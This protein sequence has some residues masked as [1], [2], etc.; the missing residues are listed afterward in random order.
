M[1][2]EDPAMPGMRVAIVT[3]IPAPYRVPVFACL[4]EAPGLAL[5]VYFCSGRE[6]DRQWNLPELG[7]DHVFLRPR[8]LTWRSR[9][10]H[11][12]PDPLAGPLA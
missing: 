3:N 10:I 8:V 11:F 7:F 6:P 9:F 2:T 1:T 12:N 5:R 4:A